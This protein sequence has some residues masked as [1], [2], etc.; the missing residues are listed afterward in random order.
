MKKYILRFH[1]MMVDIGITEEE[2]G[3]I[4]THLKI[5]YAENDMIKEDHLVRLAGIILMP[6]RKKSWAAPT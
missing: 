1:M 3:S 5:L 2:L 4:R 6:A